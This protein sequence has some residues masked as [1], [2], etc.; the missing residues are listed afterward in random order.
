MENPPKPYP[1]GLEGAGSAYQNTIHHLFTDHVERDCV[2][3]LYMIDPTKSNQRAPVVN[4]VAIRQLMDDSLHDVLSL[5]DYSE[6]STKTASSFPTFLPGFG[7][8][9]FHVRHNS[10]TRDGE[11]LMS[12][13]LTW[14]RTPITNITEM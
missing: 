3:D 1:F 7:G 14:R 11:T 12:A 8:M 6:S 4:M 9:I 10:A 13:T 5:G 2:I